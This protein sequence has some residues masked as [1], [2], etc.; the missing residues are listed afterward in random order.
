MK[1]VVIIKKEVYKMFGFT[2]GNSYLWPFRNRLLY[3]ELY[4]FGKKIPAR[5]IPDGGSPGC[6]IKYA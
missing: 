5:L 1:S 6:Y 2:S 3:G 4:C